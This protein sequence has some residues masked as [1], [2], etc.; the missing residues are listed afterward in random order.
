MFVDSISPTILPPMPSTSIVESSATTLPFMSPTMPPCAANESVN[1]VP[2]KRSA[3]ALKL[4]DV[5][6]PLGKTVIALP[7]PSPVSNNHTVVCC[8]IILKL[9]AGTLSIPLIVV[10]LP[11]LPIP[12]TVAVV[13]PIA[14]VA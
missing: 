4:I 7:S 8:N 2:N 11:A 6:V 5:L 10:V 13:A 3:S 9:H 1:G 14:S 12:I